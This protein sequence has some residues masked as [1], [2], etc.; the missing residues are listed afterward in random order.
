MSPLSGEE[1]ISPS[2]MSRESVT[3]EEEGAIAHAGD[4]TP[5]ARTDVDGPSTKTTIIAAVEEPVRMRG[6]TRDFGFLPIPRRLQ[7]D[8]SRAFTFTTVLN[9]TFGFSST[10]SKSPCTSFVEEPL[11]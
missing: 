7:Y 4:T 10:F 6:G 11:V 3:V 1:S 8:P 2:R 5:I 9:V